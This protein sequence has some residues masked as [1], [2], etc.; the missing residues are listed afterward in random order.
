MFDLHKSYSFNKETAENGAKMFVG[1]DPEEYVLICRLPNKEYTVELTRV[2]AANGK[3][4]EFLKAQDP[5]KFEEKDRE[6][7]ADVL[8]KTVITGWGAKFGT[9]GKALKYS[10]K[11]CAEL[12]KEYPDFRADCLTF[13][14]DVANYPAEVDIEHTVKK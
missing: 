5:V 7:Q 4:L 1:S 3:L 12:I 6:L 10:H 11:K 8:A 14:T 13:A 9:G 2:M